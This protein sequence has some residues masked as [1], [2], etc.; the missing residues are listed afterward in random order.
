MRWL[1][2]RSLELDR[3]TERHAQAH[4]RQLGRH[5]HPQ[6]RRRA[7]RARD[8]AAR[9]PGQ[10]QVPGAHEPRAAHAAERGARLL[11]AAAGRGPGQRRR[12]RVAARRLDHIRSAGQHLLTLIN[13]VLDLSSLEGGELRIAAAAG[14]AGAAGRADAGAAGAADRRR[15]RR[16]RERRRRDR[17]ARRRASIAA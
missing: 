17:R 14:G 3:R 1:A 7:P 12:R 13:D 8:R 16:Q 11:A 9:E 4:R 10:E 2:S 5:R 6:R 15:S